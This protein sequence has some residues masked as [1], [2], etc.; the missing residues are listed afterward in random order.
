MS[1]L[2]RIPLFAGCGDD[3]I[4]RLL[5]H[6]H[7]RQTY[8]AGEVVLA[9]GDACRSLMLLTEGTVVCHM[10]S[11]EGRE[12]V[13]NHF[14]APDILAPAFLFA[15]DNSVPISIVAHTRCEVLFIN[16]EGFFDFM[17]GDPAVL[18]Q[19]LALLSARGRFLSEKVRTFAVKGMRSRILDYLAVHHAIT[20]ISRT[21][22]QLG[23]A[24][25]SLSRLLS[26]MIDEG[27]LLRTAEGIVRA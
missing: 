19:F 12:L 18:R 21:A 24:R 7:Q 6:P 15:A 25:P 17:R 16:R 9:A 11:D 26:E 3:D 8:A 5:S 2:K 4:A 22:Q 23:V 27:V 20:N 10:A 1:D 13:V 14:D